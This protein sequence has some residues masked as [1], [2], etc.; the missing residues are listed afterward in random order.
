MRCYQFHE[1]K[2]NPLPKSKRGSF[3]PS[4]NKC[5]REKKKK[6]KKGNQVPVPS[7]LSGL[8]HFLLTTGARYDMTAAIN[9]PITPCY[10]LLTSLPCSSARAGE[11]REAFK[12]EWV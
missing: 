11:T 1:E 2:K 9:L 10:P 8:G 7:R 3:S 6:R 4:S 12:V 5:G